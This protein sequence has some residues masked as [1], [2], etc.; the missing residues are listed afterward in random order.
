MGKKR[1]AG[2]GA[3][4]EDSGKKV[5]EMAVERP[6]RTLL[7]W[8]DKTEVVEEKDDESGQVFRNKEKVLVSCSRRIT[9][10]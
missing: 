7:G 4:V 1:K 6:K 9:F 3:S 10:R 5:E 8:K 2:D